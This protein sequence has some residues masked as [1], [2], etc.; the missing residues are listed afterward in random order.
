[1]M[2]KHIFSYCILLL[3]VVIPLL[4]S[5]CEKSD[6]DEALQY[7]IN[8]NE[9]TIPMYASYQELEAELD[10]ALYYESLGCLDWYENHRG[11]YS[12]GHLS[13]EFVYGL[14]PYDYPTVES[15]E[16]L[17]DGYGDM[18]DTIVDER[19]EVSITPKWNDNPY[20]YIANSDGLF[21]VGSHVSRIL[22]YGIVT[23]DTSR[24][25]E[26]QQATEEA[27]YLLDSIEYSTGIKGWINH[28]PEIIPE[29]HVECR[30]GLRWH[31][32]TIHKS[33]VSDDGCDRVSLKLISQFTDVGGVFHVK[34]EIL[35]T[36]EHKAIWWWPEKHTITCS[37]NV[38]EHI[39]A[40]L[41]RWR[42]NSI[43]INE[44]K[45][46]FQIRE[47]VGDH[48]LGD[49]YRIVDVYHYLSY[50]LRVSSTKAGPAVIS[51]NN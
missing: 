19:R 23:L 28:K 35:A 7:S 49:D 32:N 12:I 2:N 18:I 39:K 14:S 15:L 6:S 46:A 31:T 20:R 44:S 21:I 51:H 3:G 36:N 47:L 11:W 43:S 48:F 29:Y 4:F 50:N 25:A 40:G 9:S 17:V 38:E 5:S 30:T 42:T 45:T 13:D 41:N 26:L 16:Q 27:A 10:S 24:L 34:T 8:Q 1:M 33:Q 22:K 37:G